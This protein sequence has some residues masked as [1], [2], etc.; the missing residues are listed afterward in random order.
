MHALVAYEVWCFDI[1]CRSAPERTVVIGVPGLRV[2]TTIPLLANGGRMLHL[3]VRNN[4]NG[5]KIQ[6]FIRSMYNFGAF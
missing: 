3:A 6:L 2:L 4:P 1:D 5:A